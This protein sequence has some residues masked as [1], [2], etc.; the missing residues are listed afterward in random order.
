MDVAGAAPYLPLRHARIGRVGEAGL[1]PPGWRVEHL[2][3]IRILDI[4]FRGLP[5]ITLELHFAAAIDGD[6][7]GVGIGHYLPAPK[8]AV[9]TL[10]STVSLSALDNVQAAFLVLRDWRPGGEFVA[11]SIVATSPA[12]STALTVSRPMSDEGNIAEA[13]FLMKRHTHEAGRATVTL[14]GLAFG[15]LADHNER[16]MPP[17]G[18]I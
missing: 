12:A 11:Q 17:A 13:V 14:R 10:S 7:A 8:G 2:D 3:S 5:W 6:Y 9:V 16:R 15:D 1:L 4:G 18:N